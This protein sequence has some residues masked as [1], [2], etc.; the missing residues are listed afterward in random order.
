M[1]GYLIISNVHVG[2]TT[3]HDIH[4][5]S[6]WRSKLSI[7]FLTTKYR[8]E[9]YTT[10]VFSYDFLFILCPILVLL[11]IAKNSLTF[12]INLGG[13][14]NGNRDLPLEHSQNFRIENT[15]VISL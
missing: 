5:S 6:K 11:I 9:G 14:S 12:F 2:Y 4:S 10:I 8:C 13:S 15:F 1:R 7:N 3:H